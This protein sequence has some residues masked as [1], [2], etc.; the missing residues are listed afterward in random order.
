MAGKLYIRE[1]PHINHCPSKL[2]A[3]E[4]WNKESS[5]LWLAVMELRLIGLLRME[6]VWQIQPMAVK[7]RTQL[8]VN[9]FVLRV[10]LAFLLTYSDIGA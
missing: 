4:R 7:M 1:N 9:S 3:N 10:L 2:C 6:R 5:G 8:R